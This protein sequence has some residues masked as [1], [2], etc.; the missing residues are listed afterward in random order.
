MWFERLRLRCPLDDVIGTEGGRHPAD[1][2]ALPHRKH[3][4][5]TEEA[6]IR[7]KLSKLPGVAGLEFNLI[8]RTLAVSHELPSLAPVEQAL[9]A[10][11]MRAIRADEAPATQ[12]RYLAIAQMDCPT[13]EG[14]IRGMLAG[15]AGVAALDFNLAQRTLRVTHAPDA[16]PG[17]L[18]ALRSLGFE[19]EVRE[20]AALANPPAPEPSRV[21]TGGRSRYRA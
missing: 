18:A 16:L 1:A 20:A 4:C 8:Q 2:G 12:A 6:L 15:T 9:S 13:E 10:I 11:G 17:V 14:L 3:E 19:A 21:P 7:D 5:P